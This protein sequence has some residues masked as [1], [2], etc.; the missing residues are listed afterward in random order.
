MIVEGLE[1]VSYLCHFFIV[2]TSQKTAKYSRMR[3]DVM[4]LK[5][6]QMSL[7]LWVLARVAETWLACM[8]KWQLIM[9]LQKLTLW[10][11]ST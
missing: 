8:H 4:W 3:M 11:H 10:T 2:L 7:E 5:M 1:P 6:M 9:L